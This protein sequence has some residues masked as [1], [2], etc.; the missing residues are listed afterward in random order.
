MAM[1]MYQKRVIFD[2]CRKK[3]QKYLEIFIIMPI[4][5]KCYVR[6]YNMKRFVYVVFSGDT[7]EAFSNLS[8]VTRFYPSL[9]YSKAYRGLQSSSE[10][11]VDGYRLI[12]LSL[13]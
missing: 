10:V 5:A 13:R 7:V 11:V 9:S 3:W 2:I 8:K 1:D 4:F 6:F 12:K